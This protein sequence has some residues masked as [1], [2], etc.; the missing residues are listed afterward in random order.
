VKHA[1]K[2]SVRDMPRDFKSLVELHMPHALHDEVGYGNTMEVIDALTS[3]PARTK[4]QAEYL[5]TLTILAEAYERAHHAIDTSEIS[6]LDALKHLVEENRITGVALGRIL[7]VKPP[8]VSMIVNGI[9]PITADH[10]R[11][12]GRRFGLEP[13]I[14]IA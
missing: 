13:G 3:I 12:L 2:T 4:D 9:R 11:K 14:F 6:G 5:D 1:S 7:G 10:A 8:A